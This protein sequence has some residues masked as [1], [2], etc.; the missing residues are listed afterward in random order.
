MANFKPRVKNLQV[1][2]LGAVYTQLSDVEI[3]VSGWITY[4][5]A[6][7][8]MTAEALWTLHGWA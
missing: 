5:R 7:A 4:D 6:V 1:L 8:K 3:E 2:C